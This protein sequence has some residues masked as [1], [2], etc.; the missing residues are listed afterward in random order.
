[1]RLKYIPLLA[2]V[3]KGDKV[4]TSSA[5]SI[6]PAGILVGSV[7]GVRNDESFQT[8][9]TVEVDPQVRASA[10]KEL[11]VITDGRK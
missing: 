8:A 3:R 5:S 1:V 2:D 10:V 11:F 9:L 6:F 7:S 4:Y